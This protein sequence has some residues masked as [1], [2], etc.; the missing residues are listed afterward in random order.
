[1]RSHWATARTA[2]SVEFTVVTNCFAS[3]IKPACHKEG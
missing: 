3:S 1:M 2:Q